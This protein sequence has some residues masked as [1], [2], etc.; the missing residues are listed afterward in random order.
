M[1]KLKGIVKKVVETLQKHKVVI[2]E[3]LIIVLSLVF[4]LAVIIPS[5]SKGHEIAEE[6]VKANK[7]VTEYLM[8]QF[9][10]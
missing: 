9:K 1:A 8:D 7:P 2:R 5:L 4:A 3:V 10:D 6:A